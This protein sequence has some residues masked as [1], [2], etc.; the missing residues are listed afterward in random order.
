VS[1]N[2]VCFAHNLF[3]HSKYVKVVVEWTAWAPFQ[4]WQPTKICRTNCEYE[5]K[6]R[7]YK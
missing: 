5:T 2:C 3:V 1:L 6:I 4:F 7:V